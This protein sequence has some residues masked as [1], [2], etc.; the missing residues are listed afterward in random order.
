MFGVLFISFLAC[1]LVSGLDDSFFTNFQ[2]LKAEDF[3]QQ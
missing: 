3:E 1:L 2:D